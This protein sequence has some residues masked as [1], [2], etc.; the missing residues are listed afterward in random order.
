MAAGATYWQT[1]RHT[2]AQRKPS[3]MPPLLASMILGNTTQPTNNEINI[4]PVGS[5][6]FDANNG[7]GR[8]LVGLIGLFDL[9]GV[10]LELIRMPPGPVRR[11]R[12]VPLRAP[13]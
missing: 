7:G 10:M 11:V 8:L 2:F 5:N 12:A 4:P 1:A 3:P 9:I 13:A 6:I